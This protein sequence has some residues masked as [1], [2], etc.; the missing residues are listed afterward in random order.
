[1]DT[2][3]LKSFAQEARTSLLQQVGNKLKMVLVDSSAARRE[4]PAAIKE[5]EKAIKASSEA[6]VTEQVAYTWFNR[7]CALRFLDVKRYSKVLVV[8]P[9]EGQFQ[10]E[11]LAEAKAGVFDENL[12]KEESQ[13][14]KIQGLLRGSVP[15]LDPQGEAY[16]LL[17]VAV[18]NSW[19]ETMPFLFEPIADYTELLMPDDLLAGNSILAY[20]REAMAPDTCESVEVI[21]WLY[22]FYI[23]EK[24][25]SVMARKS[26]VPTEDIPAVTQLFTPHW[27]VRY[28]VENSLGRLWLLNNPSSTLREKMPYYIEGEAESDFLKIGKPE[29]IKVLDPACGSGH[30]LTYAF[31]L[32]YA[33]YEEQGYEAPS[34]PGL[35]LKH[36]LYGVDICPRAAALAAFALA[37]KAR[38]K[39]RRFFAPDNRVLPNITELQDIRIH[40]ERLN[41]AFKEAGKDTELTQ[42]WHPLSQLCLQFEEAKN[43][44]SLIQPCLDEAAIVKARQAILNIGEND[45]LYLQEIL[46]ILDQA[47]VLT[48]RY[49]VVVANPPYMGTKGMTPKFAAFAKEHFP[50]SRSDMSAAFLERGLQFVASRGM[51]AMITMQSW[52]FL[53]SLKGL[54]KSI[55]S[56]NTILNMAHCGVRAFDSIGGEVVSTTAFVVARS[57]FPAYKGVFVRLKEGN[58]E[59]EKDK[60]LRVAAA[61]QEQSDIRFHASTDDFLRIPGSPIAYWVSEMILKLFS[62]EKCVGD[63]VKPRQGMSTND[64]TRFLRQWFEVPQETTGFSYASSELASKSGRKWFPYNKGGTLRKWYGNYE[65]VVNWLNDGEEIKYW[66]INNPKDPNTSHW[67]RRIIN[68]EFYFKEGITWADITTSS[69]AARHANVGSLF[70]VKGSSAFPDR[71][72]Q[73][74]L[75]ALMNCRLMN[76]F[77]AILNPTVT[78]QVGDIARV[79]FVVPNE[80]PEDCYARVTEMISIARADWDNFET[81]W[82]FRDLPLLRPE[83]K[84]TALEASW[85]N[86]EAQSTAAIRRMQ[87]LET[88]NNRLFIQ[89]YG[90]EGELQPEVP[91]DQITLA[92]ADLQKDMVAFI[93]YAVGCMMGRYS[94]D[95]PGLILANAGDTIAD[96][97]RIVG[98]GKWEVGSSNDAAGNNKEEAHDCQKLS[99]VDCVAEVD[100]HGAVGLSGHSALSQGGALRFDESSAPSGGVGSFQHCGG[101]SEKLNSGVQELLV[102]STR[103]AG[104]SGNSNDDCSPTGLSAGGPASDPAAID[105]GNQAHDLRADRKTALTSHFPLPTSHL[106]FV[107]DEDGIIPVLDG[108]WFEDDI[109]ARFRVFLR[110]TFGDLHFEQNLAFIESAL[111]NDLRSYFVKDFYKNHVQTYKKRPIYWMF[112]SA[113]GGF[114]ALVYLHRYRPDTVSQLLNGYLRQF[115]TK[116]SLQQERLQ[117]Q[118]I[119]SNLSAREKTAALKEL[120]KLKKLIAEVELYERDI[121]FPLATQN[122]DIDLDD[123][124]KVNYLK[125]GEALKTITGLAAKEDE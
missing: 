106:T 55:L 27:I 32:L 23:S 26:A 103:F 50:N 60:I 19:H 98:S 86:W 121:I 9:A 51:V 46:P 28:L 29:E 45:R 105:R 116:L 64:N 25:D 99:R 16:R 7:F 95:K 31:D 14:L 66:L 81:S 118:S 78:F 100:G 15:S 68:T 117:A 40:E 85:K 4:S 125:F 33:I 72:H 79:P 44:G 112:S 104:G 111:G 94:L 35:I 74:I 96:Y 89:A 76:V 59:S 119:N 43:F 97:I 48:Q 109:V 24:K 122:L 115:R 110:T 62:D 22:Q 6:Q 30:M 84:S 113:K 17:V 41:S 120:E 65:Y 18:C 47:E 53:S 101:A 82:D 88:E 75:L 52:M 71:D 83:L 37:M 39:S 8:S 11:I 5:L 56:Q 42:L 49:H 20:T 58:C 21:G 70:D 3:K 77:M 123:G 90:L 10:P 67:S 107:P 73:Y 38:E 114:Q 80:P 63:I 92:R 124:V 57:S 87:E 93:S 102:D 69:F 12:I 34:I 1:M 91:E 108:E 61:R 54:R 2:S 13:R 36:N